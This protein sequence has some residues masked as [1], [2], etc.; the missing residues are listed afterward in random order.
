MN[1]SALFKFHVSGN[2]QKLSGGPWTPARRRIPFYV[3]CWVLVRNCLAVKPCTA[4]RHK[5]VTQFWVFL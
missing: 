2:F 5:H 3:F 1:P 4:R